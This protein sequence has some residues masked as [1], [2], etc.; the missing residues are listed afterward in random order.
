MEKRNIA[1]CPSC[2]AMAQRI[3]D[4]EAALALE[5][6]ARV[7]CAEIAHEA[8]RD[9]DSTRIAILAALGAPTTRRI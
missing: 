5:V 6:K 3:R 9:L 8:K 1:W 7:A 4:L 2:E